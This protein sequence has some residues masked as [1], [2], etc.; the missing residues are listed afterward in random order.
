MNNWDSVPEFV[1]LSDD[2]SLDT[3][4][5]EANGTWFD[6]FST[7][8]NL[9]W[10]PSNSQFAQEDGKLVIAATDP[11]NQL[12]VSRIITP[13]SNFEVECRIKFDY[14]GTDNG[15]SVRW[16][17]VRIV[18]YLYESKIRAGIDRV[19]SAPAELAY[20]DVGYDWHTYRVSFHDGIARLYFDGQP[21]LS[22]E[23]EL[24]DGTAEMTFFTIPANQYNAAKMQVEY[25]SYRVLTNSDLVITTPTPRETVE[26]GKAVEVTASLSDSLKNSGESV[27]FYLNNV[28]A[29]EAESSAPAVCFD[30]LNPGVYSVYATCGSV[31]SCERIFSV[32]SPAASTEKNAV[33][34]TAAKLQSSYILRYTVSG[35][36]S[37]SAGDGL[38]PLSLEYSGGRLRCRADDGEKTV[39][40]GNGAYIAAVDGGVLWLWKNGKL[41]LSDRLPQE[42]CGT[43][44]SASGS[45][46]NVAVEA[47]NGTLWQRSLSGETNL[48]LDPGEI[49]NS[50][51]LEFAYSVGSPL[52]M[53]FCDGLYLLGLKITADGALSI[54]EAPQLETV[55]A[56]YGSLTGNAVYRV[57]VSNGVAIL[58]RNNLRLVSFRMPESAVSRNL[59]VQGAGL[60]YLQIRE[61][62]ERFF[63]SGMPTDSDW[64][65]WFA[66]SAKTPLDQGEGKCLKLYAHNT[67][68]SATLNV[69]ALT[70][71]S[72][73]LVARYFDFIGS[74]VIAGYDFD[75]KCFK[76]GKSIENLSKLDNAVT[77][78]GSEI[79][80][81]LRVTD[82]TATLFCN[83]EA[84]GSF[85][86]DLNGWGNVGYLNAGKNLTFSSFAFSG[87]SNALADSSTVLLPNDHTVGLFELNGKIY[88]TGEQ[89]TY[90]SID[91]GR[92]FTNT[93]DFQH[94]SYNMIV[95]QSGKLLSL[96]RTRDTSGLIYQ[97]WQSEDGGKTWKGPFNV[98]STYNDYRFTMNGKVMQTSSG[99]IF[100]V[101]GETEDENI[102]TNWIYYSDNDG[103]TW[104]KSKTEF[105]QK[106]T[107]MNIQEGCIVE[108]RE[109][110][111]RFYARNDCG[112]LVYSDSYDGG[113]TWDTDMK[114]SDFASVVSAFNVAKDPKTGAIWMT[115]EYNNIN[116]C[117]IIQY[118]R[119][120]IGLA[121]SYDN[122]ASW[123][124]IGDID[125]LNQCDFRSVA[126]WNLGM[127]ITDDAVFVTG[128][129]QVDG[130]WYNY[131]VRLSK[132]TIVPMARFNSLYSL[133][134]NISEYRDGSRLSTMGVLAISPD[135][136][137]VWAS[138]R[139]FEVE[140][141]TDKRTMLPVEIIASFL[142]G[143]LTVTGK[144]ATI[145]VGNAEYVFTARSD[146]AWIA[147]EEKVMTFV[148]GE[149]DGTVT[150]S[151]EDLHRLLD[152]YAWT[153]ESGAIL[154]TVGVIP[155]SNVNNLLSQV[156]LF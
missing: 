51:A 147:R 31:I 19:G 113:K 156:G 68:I 127:W 43:V 75:S 130:K 116:D 17:G 3:K 21:L 50:Y 74:G 122:A 119:T 93:D 46:G 118:P 35:D 96:V 25:A 120:R 114:F 100:F 34:A 47:Y 66:V 143:S 117:M 14:F 92:T 58:F 55:Y 108:L 128:G 59:Y 8:R 23:P 94:R 134:N 85:S 56:E 11:G 62:G 133:R 49:G 39:M 18:V 132:E 87:D 52:S 139:F 154:L 135:T 97:A 102:G 126:H 7:S 2:K 115:W 61:A 27:K 9:Y 60:T 101:S 37:L 90:V 48:S 145:R 79:T 140:D 4:G 12:Y 98:Q 16:N 5:T 136:G 111:L 83:G 131:T 95:L 54:L 81:T 57:A 149:Q 125:G 65:S 73:Y 20:V 153:N 33:Y 88:E 109:G 1:P 105:N 30:N 70:T 44:V 91:G 71:G 151:I 123:Q 15:F 10:G 26:N 53:S 129:K 67:E 24:Q 110:V 72:F 86:T 137:R 29:G 146:V 82:L 138:G 32:A 107:G 141:V 155:F 6:S 84:V 148:A 77:I 42:V 124:Y 38:F 144:T 142:G 103:M 13:A 28:Y 63:W 69:S 45:I 78:A 152:L 80:L 36:G 40:A 22:F 104:K 89:G 99:R 150:V 76:Y 41:L 112:F 64:D 106:T 121:V